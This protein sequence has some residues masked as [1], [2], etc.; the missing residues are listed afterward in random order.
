ME[1]IKYKSID[2]SQ[3]N[4]DNVFLHYTNNKNLES[5]FNN[6]LIPKIGENSKIIE[7]TKKIFFSVGV[8]GAIVIMDSWLKWLVGKPIGNWIY[9]TGAVLLKVSF[10]PKSIHKIIVRINKNKRKYEWSYNKLKNI[11]DNSVYL[12]LDLEENID[13]NFFDIDEVKSSKYPKDFIESFYAYNSN[14]TDNTMEYWNMHTI[15]NKV[16][17]PEKISILMVNNT[18]CASDILKSFIENNLEFV[19]QNCDVLYKYYKYIY[20]K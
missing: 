12:V 19:K 9:Y 2:I 20:S 4:L 16:I 6:G 10:F 3:L 17:E 13:F 14:I 8:E 18:V 5:I 15:S 1:K 11:L 7:K